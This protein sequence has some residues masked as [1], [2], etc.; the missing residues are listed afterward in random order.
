M[1]VRSLPERNHPWEVMGEVPFTVPRRTTVGIPKYHQSGPLGGDVPPLPGGVLRAYSRCL[2]VKIC[3]PTRWV[4][5]FEGRTHIEALCSG[6]G[7]ASPPLRWT[8]SHGT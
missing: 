1:N 6:R 5:V 3:C 2:Q 7:G 8:V 4:T